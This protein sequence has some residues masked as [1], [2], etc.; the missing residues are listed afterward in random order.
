MAQRVALLEIKELNERERANHAQLMLDTVKGSL[1][2]LELRNAELEAR[3]SQLTKSALDLQTTEQELRQE[4]AGRFC[5]QPK[6]PCN[7]ELRTTNQISCYQLF[8][9][10]C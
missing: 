6:S 7:D 10:H 4:L 3:V 9:V 2:Q 1:Q 5:R 8:R